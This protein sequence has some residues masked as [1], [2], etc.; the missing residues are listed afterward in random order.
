MKF[1]YLSVVALLLT[2][3]A[4]PDFNY[5][6]QSTK[7]SEPPLDSVNTAYVGD[8][9][10]RQGEFTEHDAIFVSSKIDV[11]YYDIFP[12]YYLKR[13]EDK[14]TETYTPA[15]GDE[16]GTIKKSIFAGP[17][18]AVIIYKNENKICIVDNVNVLTCKKSAAFERRKKPILSANSFQQTLLYNGTVGDKINIGYRE[19]S[20]SLARPAF[21]N[22][23]EYDLSESKTIGYK[24]AR[25][26][27]LEAN[28]ESIKYRVIRNFN[29][30]QL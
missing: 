9:L 10:L 30:A 2:A 20:N 18:Q 1:L 29:N 25:I 14:N 5:A 3:C 17:W 28:N 26:E 7:V 19:F 27:V 16:S 22:D 15:G 4:T 12:G 21:N 8:V 13:G 24:G 6:P 11:P 23:V